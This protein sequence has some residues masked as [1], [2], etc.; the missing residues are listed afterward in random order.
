ML[1]YVESRRVAEGGRY[2]IV[3]A[4]IVPAATAPVGRGEALEHAE[5]PPRNAKAG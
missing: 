2:V 1:M 5:V 4:R 3:C